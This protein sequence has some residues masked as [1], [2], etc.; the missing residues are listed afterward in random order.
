MVSDRASWA[1][2]EL[3]APG[4][5]APHKP[6]VLVCGTLSWGVTLLWRGG[7]YNSASLGGCGLVIERFCSG[8]ALG[9]P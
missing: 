4:P 1:T 2:H 8:L 6:S 5:Q 3:S 7:G 9:L